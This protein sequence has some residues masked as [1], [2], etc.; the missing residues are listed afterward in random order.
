VTTKLAHLVLSS[1]RRTTVVLLAGSL[2]LLA[3]GPAGADTPE[4]W[5]VSDKVDPVHAVL[6]LAGMPLLLI[7]VIAVLVMVP[8]R[9]REERHAVDGHTDDQWFGG[10]RQGTAELPAAEAVES[11]SGGASARW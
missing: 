1:V 2:V 8:G 5:P 4:G 9:T 3:S 10:P 7:A 11:G 6:L